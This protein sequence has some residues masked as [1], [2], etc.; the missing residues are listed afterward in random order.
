MSR[1]GFFEFVYSFHFSV[2]HHSFDFQFPE[3]YRV[4]QHAMIM[5]YAEGVRINDASGIRA[6]GLDT[7][8]VARLL[9]EGMLVLIALPQ[10]FS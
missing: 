9:T 6:L 1:F 3:V 4:S 8:S 7:G 10:L 2:C 5:E